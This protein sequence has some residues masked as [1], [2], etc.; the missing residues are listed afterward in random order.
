MESYKRQQ[1]DGL[2]GYTNG[3]GG[4][5]AANGYRLRNGLLFVSSD[6]NDTMKFDGAVYHRV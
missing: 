4:A 6:I 1:N 5:G 2:S 3:T